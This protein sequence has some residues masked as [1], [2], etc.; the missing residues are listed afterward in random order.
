LKASQWL[1]PC[2]LAGRRT[3]PLTGLAG[4][5]PTTFMSVEERQIDS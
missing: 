2:E 1:S 3:K 4:G 5:L